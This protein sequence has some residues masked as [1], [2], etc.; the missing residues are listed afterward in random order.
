MAENNISVIEKYITKYPWFS[1]GYIEAYRTM[2]SME[3][4][5]GEAYLRETGLNDFR[6]RVHGDLIRLEVPEAQVKLILSKKKDICAALQQI[7]YRY[8]TL[9]L[10]NLTS[11]SFDR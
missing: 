1:I 4:E 6:L 3:A 2:C 11:G 8:I 7:G 5:L 9:D 10:E